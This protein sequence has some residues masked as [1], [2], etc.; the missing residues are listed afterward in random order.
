MSDEAPKSRIGR[1]V[2]A[3]G[4]GL[5]LVIVVAFNVF[6]VPRVVGGDRPA[7][8]TETARAAVAALPGLAAGLAAAPASRYTGTFT[9]SGQDTVYDIDARVTADGTLLGTIKSADVIGEILEIGDR[10]FIRAAEGFWTQSR[11]TDDRRTVFANRWVLVPQSFLGLDLTE[12]FGPA[13]LTAGL[14][15][16]ATRGTTAPPTAGSATPAT[17]ESAAPGAGTGDATAPP[18]GEA[19]TPATGGTTAPVADETTAPGTGE[20]AAPVAGARATVGDVAVQQ[21]TAGDRTFALSITDPASLVSVTGT[22]YDLKPAALDEPD[23]TAFF[24]QLR[25]TA[26]ELAWAADLGSRITAKTRTVLRACDADSCTARIGFVNRIAPTA[27]YVPSGAKTEA[28]VTITLTRKGKTV[29]TCQVPLSLAPGE[30][31]VAV[32]AAKNQPPATGIWRAT[33]TGADRVL[34]PTR[35]KE[36]TTTLETELAKY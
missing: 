9:A 8:A 33:H 12:T 20:M 6:V 19:A 4:I 24:A 3:A 36:I 15:T 13:A 21:V 32:C 29:K 26:N 35:V 1:R 34:T 10:A 28:S 16:P 25:K 7:S 18:T 22:G 5:A 14:A 23:R 31:R 11:I 27:T 30:S 17:A 2:V